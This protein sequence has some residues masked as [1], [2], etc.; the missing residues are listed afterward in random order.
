MIKL[1]FQYIIFIIIIITLISYVIMDLC[2]LRCKPQ[3]VSETLHYALYSSN[4]TSYAIIYKYCK[5]N[6]EW[7]PSHA[8]NRAKTTQSKP[9]HD[10]NKTQDRPIT[11]RTQPRHG[12][13]E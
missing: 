10:L 6:T 7:N 4:C 3:I 13:R 1:C 11:T 12:T 8:P 9:I 5:Y 2:N